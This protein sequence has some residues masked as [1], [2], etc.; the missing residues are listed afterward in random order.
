MGQTDLVVRGIRSGTHR[1]FSRRHSRRTRL[2][3][4][5]KHSGYPQ[6]IVLLHRIEDL[7]GPFNKVMNR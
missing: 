6:K 1:A 7:F 3:L 5:D 2:Q 4:H